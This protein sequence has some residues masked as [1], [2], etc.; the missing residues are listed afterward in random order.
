MAAQAAAH[1][2][3]R[4][5]AGIDRTDACHKTLRHPG[6][7][8]ARIINQNRRQ[9]MGVFTRLSRFLSQRLPL[10]AC[11]LKLSSIADSSACRS[12]VSSRL[13]MVNTMAVR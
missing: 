3:H 13:A 11:V 12:G 10:A 9:G 7:R 2:R 5:P 4:Q 1:V 8:K 6:L